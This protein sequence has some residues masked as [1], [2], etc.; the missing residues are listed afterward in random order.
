M[1]AAGGGVHLHPMHPPGYAYAMKTIRACDS[2]LHHE[3]CNNNNNNNLE[4]FIKDSKTKMQIYSLALLAYL[5]L[6]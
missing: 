4:C 1:Q 3:Q 2:S 6:T 5:L